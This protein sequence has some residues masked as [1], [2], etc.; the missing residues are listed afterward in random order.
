MADQPQESVRQPIP[1]RR[2]PQTRQSKYPG[3][4]RRKPHPEAGGVPTPGGDPDS[5]ASGGEPETVPQDV[6]REQERDKGYN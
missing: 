4:D 5:N 6:V 2:N 3:V 1:D